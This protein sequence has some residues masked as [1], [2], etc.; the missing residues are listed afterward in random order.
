VTFIACFIRARQIL[1]GS[2]SDVGSAE[3]YLR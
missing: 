3:V 1:S 2:D